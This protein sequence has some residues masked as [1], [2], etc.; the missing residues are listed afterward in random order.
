ML[1]RLKNIS[2][3]QG[4]IQLGQLTLLLVIFMGFMKHVEAQE[5]TQLKVDHADGRFIIHANVLI[6]APLS[7][8]QAVLTNFKNLS[9]LNPNIK[10]VEILESSDAD[11]TRMQIQS[12]TC[13][14]FFCL[15][16]QWV[17]E[18]YVLASNDIITQ[19]DPGLSDF[20]KGWV[21]YRLLAEGNHTRLVT[22]ADLMPS[23]WIPPVLGPA[24]IKHSLRQ[25]SLAIALRIEQLTGHQPS[26][27]TVSKSTGRLRPSSST[28]S[29]VNMP[30]EISIV[31]Q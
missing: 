15:D 7:Q 9:A 22:D 3:L 6:A 26:S 29:T 30:K 28:G 17:Q 4:L 14:L 1:K 11:K 20:R 13:I 25:E 16:Y 12:R 31:A 27:S 24:L 21:R 23:F 18:T 2:A 8:V 10:T 19:F 5:V